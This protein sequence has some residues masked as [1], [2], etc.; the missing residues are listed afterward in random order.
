VDEFR[1]ERW[2]TDDLDAAAGASNLFLRG[3]RGCPGEDLILF[4]CEAAIR[5]QLG[6]SGITARPSRLSTDPLPVSFPAGDVA[7]ITR[8]E[9]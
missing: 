2:L 9:S 1:P 8:S 4:V 7:F 6:E 3:P 5:H